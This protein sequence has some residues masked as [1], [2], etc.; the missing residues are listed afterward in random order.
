MSD[1]TTTVSYGRGVKLPRLPEKANLAIARISKLVA[2]GYAKVI[3]EV[4]GDLTKM[5]GAILF[6]AREVCNTEKIPVEH[7]ISFVYNII[8]DALINAG[9]DVTDDLRERLWVGCSEVVEQITK[10]PGVKGWKVKGKGKKIASILDFVEGIIDT[11]LQK[12]NLQEKF[13]KALQ[14]L[15]AKCMAGY[16]DVAKGGIEQTFG[17]IVY[18][19]RNVCN[20][21]LIPKEEKLAIALYISQQVLGASSPVGQAQLL[22]M[23]TEVIEQIIFIKSSSKWKV[24]G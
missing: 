24:K 20:T 14:K 21:K 9:V 1:T 18:V 6:V 22:A 19:A 4:P 2:D 13:A 5:F 17:A 23:V 7:K 15:L 11:I 8:I 10:G 3:R 16:A 12:V